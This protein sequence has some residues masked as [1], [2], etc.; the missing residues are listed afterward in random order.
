MSAHVNT[1]RALGTAVTSF[2]TLTLVPWAVDVVV[3]SSRAPRVG[4][5]LAAVPLALLFGALAGYAA[6]PRPAT[7]PL[8]HVD[9]ADPGDPSPTPPA[10]AA[11]PAAPPSGAPRQT[12]AGPRAAAAPPRRAP[13]P[14]PAPPASASRPPHHPG[15][16]PAPC[17][18]SHRAP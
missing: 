11:V 15:P 4:L 14:A 16:Q 5:L 13:A 7:G 8:G 10:A 18:T 3:H 17:P 6:A 2:A 1:R 9:V 12:R